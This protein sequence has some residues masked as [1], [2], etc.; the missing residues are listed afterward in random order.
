M[1]PTTCWSQIAASR[2]DRAALDALW[3][4]LTR[5]YWR[6]LY[7]HA[8]SRGVD[9]AAAEDAVQAVFARLFEGEIVARLD[10]HRGRLRDYLRVTLDRYLRDRR[11]HERAAKRGGDW[12]EVL[13]VDDLVASGHD[14][15]ADF[16]RAW[17]R[18]LFERAVERLR[19]DLSV[20]R[21]ELVREYFNAREPASCAELAAKY[22]LSPAAVKSLLHRARTRFRE[23]V[24]AEVAATVAS[25]ADV[26]A[27]LCHIDAALAR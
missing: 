8:R 18:M 15:S 26:D 1:F 10:P 24:R 21:F 5:A 6:P 22:G 3:D 27:E 11:V 25:A 16:D 9:G 19:A 12:V 14:P 2:E 17:A 7:L 20:E 23:L 4:R 13:L